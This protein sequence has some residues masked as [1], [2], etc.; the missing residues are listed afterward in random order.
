M[1]VINEEAVWQQ[2]LPPANSRT[3]TVRIDMATDGNM[4]DKNKP[5]TLNIVEN[6]GT[7]N[8]SRNQRSSGK[9][10]WNWSPRE[11]FRQHSTV[12]SS[13]STDTAEASIANKSPTS[14]TNSSS[15]TR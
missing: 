14:K 5:T 13:L 7:N 1:K 2:L 15:L 11:T 3:A 4:N 8:D 9:G 10:F 12:S 6:K